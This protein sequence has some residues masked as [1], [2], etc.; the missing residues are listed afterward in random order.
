MTRFGY[1]TIITRIS[2]ITLYE[3]V[4]KNV[5][6]LYLAKVNI[7]T[8]APKRFTFTKDKYKRFPANIHKNYR[9]KIISCHACIITAHAYPKLYPLRVSWIAIR[10]EENILHSIFCNKVLYEINNKE[11]GGNV[12]PARRADN[13]AVIY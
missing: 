4:S 2:R 10:G 9:N 8:N 11:T 3:E 6:Q 12:R 1:L 7:Q 13:L 5:K